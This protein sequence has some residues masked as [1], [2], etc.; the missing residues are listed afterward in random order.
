MSSI[1][2]I[3][4]I[5]KVEKFEVDWDRILKN[6]PLKCARSLICQITAGTEKDN[7]DALIIKHLVE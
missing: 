6:D 3:F 7:E 2:F 5:I 1:F 4:G